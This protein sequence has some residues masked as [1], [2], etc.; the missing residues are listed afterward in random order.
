MQAN[1]IKLSTKERLGREL[2]SISE[3]VT[4]ED[5]QMFTDEYGY[6]RSTISDYIRG[7][8]Y[9]IDVAMKMLLFFRS[10]IAERH[11]IIETAE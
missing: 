5:R 9:N 7:H 11:R 3:E 1:E 2:K 6:K 10:R 4:A 8:V